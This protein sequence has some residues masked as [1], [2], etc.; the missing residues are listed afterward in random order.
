MNDP[1]RVRELLDRL[2]ASTASEE[3][4]R[5]LLSLTENGDNEVP[6]RKT[7][8]AL[9]D[10]Y[11]KDMTLPPTDWENIYASI[12][13]TPVAG[14]G[15]IRRLIR[16]LAVAA[17]VIFAAGTGLW[18]FFKKPPPPEKLAALPQV[19]RFKNDVQPGVNGAVLTLGNGQHIIIDSARSGTI[20]TQGNVAIVKQGEGLSYQPGGSP[21][22]VVYNTL[23]T[24]RGRQF[25]NLVLPDGSKVWLDAGSSIRFPTTFTGKERKVEITG[26]VWFN[27]V[28]NGKMPF[29][30][31]VKGTEIEDL[32]TQ[33]D[34]NAYDDE[35]CVKV[36]LLEGSI[37]LVNQG[38]SPVVMKPGEQAELNS[39]SDAV[40]H[41]SVDLDQVM[42]WKEGIFFCDDADIT[43]VMRQVARWYDVDVIFKEHIDKRVSLL[44]VPRTVTLTQILKIM[45]MTGNVKFLIDGKKVTVLSL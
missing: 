26:Q 31:M 18:L 9:W 33:F 14:R 13:A 17:A 15:K 25:P 39:G 40:I 21:A 37:Q 8:E 4:V 10:S 34:I 19:Q 11:D 5:E 23:S 42:A 24:P 29:R 2:A 38:K 32:G 28:H 41:P 22:V 16:Q 44:N 36:T 12:V 27:V 43:S 35:G 1:E 30:V 20:A 3:E 6:V 45:E 7:I